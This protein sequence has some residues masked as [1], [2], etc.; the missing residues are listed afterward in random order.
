MKFDFVQ[1]LMAVDLIEDGAFCHYKNPV[2]GEPVYLPGADTGD[3]KMDE[4]KAVGAYVR[5]VGS[6]ANKDFEDKHVRLCG[7]RL[8]KAKT[9]AQRQD[10]IMVNGAAERPGRFA[11]L[12]SRLQNTSLKEPGVWAPTLEQK[13]EIARDIHNKDFVDQMLNFAY[14]ASNYPGAPPAALDEAAPGNAAAEG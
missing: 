6:N 13:L 2:T 8:R 1:S 9:E 11:A 3:G 12:V 7:E 5:Y 4:S 10:A 14:E